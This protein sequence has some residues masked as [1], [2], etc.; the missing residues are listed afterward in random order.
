MESLF[1]PSLFISTDYNNIKFSYKDI[2]QDILAL[3]S[4]TT[5]YDLTGQIIWPAAEFLSK[6]IIDNPN[7]FQGKTVLELG[8][9]AGLSGMI[10]SQFAK[11][12]ILTDGNDIVIDLL[13][14]NLKFC[15]KKNVDVKKLTWGFENT[16]VFL[17]DVGEINQVIGADILFWPDSIKDLVLSLKCLKEKYVLEDIWLCICNRSKYSEDLFDSTLAAEELEREVIAQEK[18]IYLYKIISKKN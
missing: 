14:K 3:K 7:Y 13:E 10:A 17:E 11:K 12:V 4:S 15:G 5:D 9:G 18:E 8:A 16:K 2:V 1:D 6:F